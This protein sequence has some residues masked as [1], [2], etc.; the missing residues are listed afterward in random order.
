MNFLLLYYR[1]F[2]GWWEEN[3]VIKDAETM[4]QQEQRRG[5]Q[6]I[7]RCQTVSILPWIIK[8]N[9]QHGRNIGR[10]YVYDASTIFCLYWIRHVY[11]AIIPPSMV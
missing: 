5:L 2:V 10:A 1:R 3:R 4:N 9:S 6:Y 7:L 11:S 8:E